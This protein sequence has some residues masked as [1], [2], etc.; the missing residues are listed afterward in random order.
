ML[1]TLDRTKTTVIAL[2]CTN[3]IL[4]PRGQLGESGLSQDAPRRS[5]L[6]NTRRLLTISQQA[7]LPLIDNGFSHTD[8]PKILA[9]MNVATLIL[10]GPATQ[11]VIEDTA[12]LA[13]EVCDRVIV[14]RD[15]CSLFAEGDRQVSAESLA[16][17]VTVSNSP[18]IV[19]ALFPAKR[20]VGPGFAGLE[21][22]CTA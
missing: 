12:R 7:G 9:S 4:S 11:R 3:A 14:A 21:P 2:G 15:C 10:C 13:A 17:L 8:L 6:V 5:V 16:S 18:D 19:A 20:G 22:I 1:A